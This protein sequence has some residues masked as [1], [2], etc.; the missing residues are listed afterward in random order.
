MQ[1]SAGFW[2]YQSEASDRP[3]AVRSTSCAGRKP[4]RPTFG[5][6]TQRHGQEVG[7]MPSRNCSDDNELLR[8]LTEALRPNQVDQQVINAARAAFAWRTIDPEREMAELLD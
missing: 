6:T 4:F 8:D 3:A 7:G 1:T 5:P 2:V